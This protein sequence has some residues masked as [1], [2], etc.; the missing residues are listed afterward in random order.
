MTTEEKEITEKFFAAAFCI[1]GEARILPPSFS[2]QFAIL[3]VVEMTDSKRG[4][5][6]VANVMK[7]S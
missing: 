2:D 7:K 1:D 4:K 3:S 6:Y 5:I